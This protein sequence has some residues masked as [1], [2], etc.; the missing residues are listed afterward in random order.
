MLSIGGIFG[1]IMAAYFTENLNPNY[2]FLVNSFFGLFVALSALTISNQVDKESDREEESK[3]FYRELKQNCSEI[4]LAFKI[5]LVYRTI[6][7]FLL[8]GLI[9]PSFGDF[10]YYYQM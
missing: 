4:I 3:G 7:F 1:S 6:F 5:P 8:T 2:A 10:M 9:V